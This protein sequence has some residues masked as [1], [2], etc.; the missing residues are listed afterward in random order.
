MGLN[1]NL[2]LVSE[3]LETAGKPRK[4]KAQYPN[5]ND[6]L[7]WF[8]LAI[9]ETLEAVESNDAEVYE[10][11]MQILEQKLKEAKANSD[12]NRK[13]DFGL[14]KDALIDKAIVDFNAVHF[15][16]LNCE[17]DELFSLVSD[18]NFSKFC[19]TEREAIMSVE[20]YEKGIHPYGKGRVID[21]DY[22]KQNGKFIIFD[23]LNAKL[24]KSINFKEPELNN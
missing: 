15:A 12:E 8:S 5:D 22:K 19:E 23:S 7:L 13:K 11:C 10:K 16:G 18:S 17:Y 20:L 9:E 3:W 6:F 24:L 4:T 14:F 21:A 1:K 2:E